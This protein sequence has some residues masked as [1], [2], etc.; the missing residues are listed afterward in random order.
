[1]IRL[2]VLHTNDLHG[3]LSSERAN[4]VQSIRRT[5]DHASLLFDAGDAVTAGNITYKRSGEPILDLMS[6]VGYDGMVVGNREFHVWERGFVSKLALARFPILSANIR[7]R[8]GGMPLPC[9]PSH[10]Y[11][12][13]G[14]RITTLG[15]TV[16]IVTEQMAVRRLSAYLFDDPIKTAARLVPSLRQECDM[17]ICLSHIGFEHDRCLA[18]Q[19]EG[20]DLIIGGHSHTTLP[21]GESR[22]RTMIV[23]AGSHARWLGRVDLEI[24]DRVSIVS[25]EL[26]PL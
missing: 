11:Y 22:G 25:A 7:R 9:M 1:M 5:I 18:E 13:D 3:R 2:T 17:L 4:A 24:G 12:V 8:D 26:L 23:H 20:I 14:R 6:T 10:T 16:P 19:V 15:L 21:Q